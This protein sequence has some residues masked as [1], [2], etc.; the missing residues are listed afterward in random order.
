MDIKFSDNTIQHRCNTEKA[1]LT[2][3]GKE[4][5]NLLKR[6]LLQL[7][8][9]EFLGVFA[10]TGCK[11]LKCVPYSKNTLKQ[12]QLPLEDNYILV[13]EAIDG[14]VLSNRKELDWNS[15]KSIIIHSIE[16][17]GHDL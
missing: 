3:Y 14:D 6:R 15:I 5:A 17:I 12:F 16:K 11:P 10:P 7:L 2:A 4:C 9:A 1:M 13:F 8:A